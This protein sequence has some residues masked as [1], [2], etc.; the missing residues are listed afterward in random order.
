MQAKPDQM[1]GHYRLVEKLG[2]G[3][4]GVVWRAVD[5]TLDREVAIKILPE[6][7]QQHPER[8]ERFEREAKVLASL[9][10]PN[11]AVIH[12]LHQTNGVH[13]LAMELVDGDDLSTRLAAGPLPMLDALKL[14]AQV[15]RA[16]QSAHDRNI[17][18]RDLKPANIVLT[19]SGEA[20]VLDFGLAKVLDPENSIE[21]DETSSPT[22]TT[23][24][25]VAGMILGTPAYMSP[26]QARGKA[27]DRRTDIWSFG[28]V[29]HECL[30]GVSEFRGDTMSDSIGAILHKDPDWGVLPVDL[31]V[32]VHWLL[33]RCLTK[34]RDN[35]LHDIADARIELEQAIVD[36]EGVVVGAAAADRPAEPAGRRWLRGV[37]IVG[38]IALAATIGWWLK[39]APDGTVEPLG[40]SL[41]LNEPQTRNVQFSFSPDGSSIVYRAMGKDAGNGGVATSRLWLRR[42]DSFVAAPIPGTENADVPKFSPNGGQISFLVEPDGAD[43]HRADLRV[44]G[45]DGRPPLTI[46]MNVL[47]HGATSWVTEDRIVYVDYLDEHR[48]LSVSSGGGE[49]TVFAEI[50]ENGQFS[51]FQFEVIDGG[52][53]ILDS[54]FIDGQRAILLV[55]TRDGTE[56]TLLKNAYSAQVL[57]S[58]QLLF[59]RGKTLLSAQLD[60]SQ[61]PPALTGDIVTVLGGGSNPDDEIRWMRASRAGHLA[62][63]TGAGAGSDNRLMTIDQD[64]VVEPLIEARGAYMTPV[65]FSQDGQRLLVSMSADES[66]SELW[67]VELDTGSSRPI[68]SDQFVT[69]G[70]AWLS[71]QQFAFTSWQSIEDG[72]ILTRELRRDSKP[73]PLFDEWPQDLVLHSGDIDFDGRYALFD[74]RSSGSTQSDIWIGAVDGSSEI[75]PLI[76]TVASESRGAVSPNRRWISYV[77]NESGRPEIYARSYSLE[78]GVGETVIKVSRSGGVNPF[79]SADGKQLFFFDRPRKKLLAAT[80]DNDSGRY[81]TPDVRIESVEDLQL[82]E[83]FSEQSFVPVPG[84][85]RLAFVQRPESQQATDR[86]EVVLNWEQL[87]DR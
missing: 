78:G 33:R 16:L 80:L 41:Q 31:P 60:L 70:G 2:E 23:G 47:D 82:S 29:L 32:T 54:S 37:A 15:A 71:E 40:L 85:D 52:R 57:D 49:P 12:G 62:F 84:S 38:L 35:R 11:I 17:V 28:C 25:T 36:P 18:H 10:H 56:H 59:L 14:C 66:P 69:F 1:L 67:L 39:P 6:T 77:S 53:W 7:L 22:V 79:W 46:A 30:T 50:S 81:S 55:D 4:M 51:V 43:D 13:Y 68:A 21:S 24:G 45:L 9:H 44:V 65:R 48:L 27:T 34:D 73:R 26:E 72:E 75:R 61:T 8:L 63:V 42:L 87:L 3:G 74:V 64:G 83:L 58:R 76:A 19:K 86:I 5:T 20:K